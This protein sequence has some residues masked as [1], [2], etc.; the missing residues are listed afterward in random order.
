MCA[1]EGGR[2]SGGKGARKQR[3]RGK[4]G[5]AEKDAETKAKKPKLSRSAPLTKHHAHVP[6]VVEPLLEAHAVPPPRR[7]V[8]LQG[9][10]DLELDH[11]RVAVLV[12]RAHD[13]LVCIFF[14]RF[15]L[16]CGKRRRECV[17]RLFWRA[18]RAATSD[19]RGAASRRTDGR[20]GGRTKGGHPG[21]SAKQGRERNP[22]RPS[23]LPVSRGRVPRP[24]SLSPALTLTA[25]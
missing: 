12:H 9:R 3:R 6:A 24:L 19:A 10:Q 17:V 15:Y 4:K 23:P 20:G 18:S 1:Y 8:L 14:E 11:G 22:R 5:T 2:Q 21:L 13:L 16:F 25:T 7:V